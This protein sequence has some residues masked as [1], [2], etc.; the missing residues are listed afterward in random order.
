MNKKTLYSAICVCFISASAPAHAISVSSVVNGVVSQLWAR[1]TSGLMPF[2]SQNFSA[3]T[4]GIQGEVNKGAIA[5]KNTMEAI[6]TWQAEDQ[7]RRD[8]VELSEKLRQPS[9][10]CQ[11]MATADAVSQAETNA[12]RIASQ[13]VRTQLTGRVRPDG[14]TAA[15]LMN[16]DNTVKA[17]M[18]NANYTN[19]KFGKNTTYEYG[20]V[21]A[22]LLFSNPDDQSDT[23]APGQE[24]AVNA[25]IDRLVN[26]SAPPEKLRNPSWEKTEQGRAYT[27]MMKNYAAMKSLSA[28][29]LHEIK[30]GYI[31]KP[32]L[33]AAINQI[34]GVAEITRG[35][36]DISMMEAIAAYVKAK[37]SPNSIRDLST[38]TN[39]TTI[40]R[41][42]AMTGSFRLWMEHSSLRR[43]MMSEALLAGQ[44]SMATDSSL[45]PILD[46]QRAAAQGSGG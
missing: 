14:S 39:S 43:S 11:A 28:A 41:D 4:Q 23:Y 42:M 3:M 20:D 10:T 40:L 16:T 44:L 25:Y 21:R 12:R 9:T 15:S 30:A 38:A 17:M 32:G 29:S 13:S 24:E 33:G 19:A 26:G 46:A 31:P 37:T 22:D 5:N 8:A 35:K 6:A 1:V 2:L 7:F 18:D 27:E 36:N 34:P 45:R